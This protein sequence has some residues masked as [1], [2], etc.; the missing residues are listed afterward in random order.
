MSSQVWDTESEV[1]KISAAETPVL[2]MER[3]MKNKLSPLIVN[4]G[5]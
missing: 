1:A 3:I 5:M 4:N 2:E